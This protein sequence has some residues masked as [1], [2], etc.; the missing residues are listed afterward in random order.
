[1][2]VIEGMIRKAR[3]VLLRRG[4]AI[5]DA[6]DLV[7]QAFLNIE[8]YR[9]TG[10]VRSHEA[11]LVKAAIN[12]SID[13]ARRQQRAPFAPG[14]DGATDVFD[15]RPGPH[16]VLE[17]RTKLESVKRGLDQLSDKTR[18]ILLAR[19]IDELTVSEIAYRENMTVAA[20]EKQIARGTL[21]L[22]K[23]LDGW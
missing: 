12:L 7:Q 5:D 22:M 16:E 6:D 15:N 4:I 13:Q 20:V 1:M 23:W 9:E 2:V 3:T 10:S 19:R 17:A 21:A 18:R 11:L 14:L 8:N